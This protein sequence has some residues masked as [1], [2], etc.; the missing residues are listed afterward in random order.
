M[1]GIG[2]VN[3][4]SATIGINYIFTFQ[5]NISEVS[6]RAR[7]IAAGEGQSTFLCFITAA[8]S[9]AIVRFLLPTFLE[10]LCRTSPAV[11]LGLCSTNQSWLA[12]GIA[13]LER[14]Y[15]VRGRKEIRVS[16][17]RN[18][19][20]KGS[21]EKIIPTHHSCPEL[22]ATSYCMNTCLHSPSKCSWQVIQCKGLT[23]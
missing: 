6:S 4:S 2:K 23:R 20:W 11:F 15:H 7:K 9:L 19:C 21:R 14:Q 5:K 16:F 13:E 22:K 18:A 12:H 10:Q 1:K 8:N 3:S 17:S